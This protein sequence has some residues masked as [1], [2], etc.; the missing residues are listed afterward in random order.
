M[1][2]ILEQG[3]L[4]RASLAGFVDVA[5][6]AIIEHRQGLGL[7][8][9]VPFH[10]FAKNPFDG[11]VQRDHPQ[12][13]FVLIAVQRSIAK[14]MGWQI[15]PRHPL[16]GMEIEL[17]DYDAGMEAIDWDIMNTRDYSNQNCKCV[18]MAECLSPGPV[19]VG[20][21]QAIYVKDENAQREILGMMDGLR[22][23]PYINVA[24]SMFVQ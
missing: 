2:S 5:D 15:I 16:A 19:S 20:S 18:C 10:F 24:P 11:R 9:K 23:P 13:Q 17:L 1:R 21:F 7:E 3:L 22:Q 6:P 12:E 4:P 8:Q 14:H